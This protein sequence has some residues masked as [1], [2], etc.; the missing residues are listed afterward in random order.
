VDF[1]SDGVLDVLSG[2]WPGEL[3][4]FRGEGKGRFAAGVTIK[5]KDGKTI[6]L[7][8][9]ST[10]FASDWNGDGRL[11]LLVG[12]IEGDVHLIPHL[13]SAT[14]SAYGSAQKVIAAGK[15]I[16][17]PHG[18]SHPTVADWDRDGRLDLI[19]GAGDG[20]VHW[21]RGGG[22]GNEP[23]LEAARVLLPAGREAM[24][25]PAAQKGQRGMRAKIC[26]T[27]WNGDGALD[28][29][30]GDF[31]VSQ[32]ERKPLSASMQAALKKARAAMTVAMRDYQR[33]SQ[34]LHGL[35]RPA[36]SRA[37]RAAWNRKAQ[38]IRTRQTKAMERMR[39]AQRV[40]MQHEPP[41]SYDGFVWLAT[42]QATTVAQQR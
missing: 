38:P 8:N 7:S 9:A 11:D 6:R 15:P 4:F 31:S 35:G 37:G 10:V 2:S 26:V 20:A 41:F 34:E 14:G 16:R 3:Y 5:D 32:A 17:V 40:A 23:E 19:V 42:A 1:D 33:A 24:G 39:Q 30:V 36:A 28:L 22:N 13:G 21:Y 25:R 29:L 27:D 12:S 18:D